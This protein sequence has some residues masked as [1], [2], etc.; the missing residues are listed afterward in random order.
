MDSTVSPNV[1][2]TEG[3]VRVCFLAHNA[4]KVKGH[5]GVPGWGL[6]RSTSKSLTYMDLHKPNKKLIYA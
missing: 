5:V 3:G 2:T 1:K 4:S 6:E